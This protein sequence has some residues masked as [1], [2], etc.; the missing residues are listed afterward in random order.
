MRFTSSN[1]ELSPKEA[2]DVSQTVNLYTLKTIG[3]LF[4]NHSVST[5]TPATAPTPAP[6]QSGLNTQLSLSLGDLMKLM[7]SSQ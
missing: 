2:L 4:T 1:F 3:Q 6:A 5:P 7:K